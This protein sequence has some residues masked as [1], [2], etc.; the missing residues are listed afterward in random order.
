MATMVAE[1]DGGFTKTV[2]HVYVA[3]IAKTIRPDAVRIGVSSYSR[4]I[5]VAAARNTDGKIGLVLLSHL[6]RETGVSVRISGQIFQI[7]LPGHS[8]TT[9]SIEL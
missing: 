5:E 4:D 8:L 2:S 7:P 1:D 6:T 3:Q 9:V